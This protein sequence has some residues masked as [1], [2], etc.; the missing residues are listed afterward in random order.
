MK[1]LLTFTAGLTLAL[2]G[3]DRPNILFIFS[4]DHAPNAI[5]CYPGG[6]FDEIAPTKGIDRIA[7]EG[8]RFDRSYCTNAICGPSRA[9]ILTGKHSH[10]NGFIDN[11]SSYFDGLQTTFPDLLREAG[12]TTA[13]IGKWHLHSNPIGFDYW[14]ILPGQGAYYN[15][16]FIQMD[17]TRKRFQG[18]CNDLVTQKGLTW[19]KQ[20]ADSKKPFMAMVQYKAPHRNWAPAFRHINM[21]DDVNMP[22]PE[23]LFDNYEN[24]SSVLKEHA[25][26]IQDHMSWGNDMKMQ[27]KNLFPSHFTGG[28][29]NGQFNRLSDQDKKI[30][31][32]AY[33]DENK[34]F[35]KEMKAG[36]LDQK[37]ITSWK[38]QRYIKD[39]LAVIQSMDEGIAKILNHLDNSGLAE[40][41]IVIY[42]SDQGFYLGEHGWYDK[43]WMFEESLM[44]PFVVRWPGKIKPGSVSNAIIQNIDY[45]PTFLELAGA[46]IPESMQ[47]KSLVPIFKA[48][49]EKP[50][51]WRDSIYYR[52]SGER[53]HNV[54]AHDGVR[55]ADHK[56]FWVPKTKEYQLFDMKKDPQEMKSVHNDPAYAVVFNEMKQELDSARKKYRVHSAIIG[57]PRKDEWWMKRHQSMNKNAKKP[58]DLLFIGDSITQ[59]WEGSGKGTW[60]KYYGNRKAL[61][62][63]ISG[64]RTEHVIWR[65]DNGNLR[66]QKK[67]KAAVVMIGTNNT[68]HIM[69]DP[70]EVRD[71]VERIVSTLR[72]RCPQAKILLLGVFPRGVKPD[73]AKRKN[74]LEI[75]KFISELHN[76]ER[77]H[78][79]DISD[80]FLTAEGILT[81]QV[82]PDALHPRQKGY[83]IWAEAIE[84]K[85]KEFGL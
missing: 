34:Q 3:A 83:E 53:T 8:M 55:T 52:Y 29:G 73:D 72:A 84:P 62:L 50:K 20:A 18:H 49:G 40:N 67:A 12:Y 38:Y 36:K 30:F 16:D 71:G 4:D 11:N 23:T 69:Q 77:I 81:K 26:G 9:S 41:T 19:L 80:K 61:N 33:E 15:P 63:G 27:G 54:A 76:G 14:E 25:M 1:H 28:P 5:S 51:G 70:T 6:L 59:G 22:E 45:G 13:M 48:A 7:R 21:F 37:A 10:L 17:N 64:D 66:N 2:S 65:L 68:G 78:Y 85:L 42:S 44:M 35:I 46:K 56:I 31:I 39:Y 79:L 24:R 75:N 58:H 60:E 57:E 82:M 47:G 74:N 32:S 43:R